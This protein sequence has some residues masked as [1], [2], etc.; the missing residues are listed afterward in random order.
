MTETADYDKSAI[1]TSHHA[2]HERAGADKIN[3]TGLT[4]RADIIDRGGTTENDF[5]LSDLTTD[6]AWHSLDLSG[7]VPTGTK[8]IPIRTLIAATIVGAVGYFTEDETLGHLNMFATVTQVANAF[9][10]QEGYIVC[11]ENRKIRY[12]ITD[13]TWHLFNILIRGWA[14]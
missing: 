5:T 10:S 3:C 9:I 4:G 7:V 6:S 14:K 8:I 11:D 2:S 12:I 13:T 1:P